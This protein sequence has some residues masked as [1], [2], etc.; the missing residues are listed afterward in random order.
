MAES[1]VF[2]TKKWAWE[3]ETSWNENNVSCFV[4]HADNLLWRNL[5]RLPEASPCY[6]QRA[7]QQACC[8]AKGKRKLDNAT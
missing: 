6:K 7:Q 8:I 1:I 5:T 2:D 3:K 4:M